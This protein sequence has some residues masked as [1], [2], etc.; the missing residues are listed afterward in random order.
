MQESQDWLAALP[1][2]LWAGASL[3]PCAYLGRLTYHTRE[4]RA[5]RRRFWSADLI[6]DIPT[7]AGMA[8]VGYGVTDYLQLSGPASAA[9][10]GV[11]GYLGPR[12]VEV[13]AG[14]WVRRRQP[15]RAEA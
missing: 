8:L 9:M 2:W 1:A 13:L 4:V 5:G 12:G 14:W 6:L 11:L 7:A 3:V 15:P 10:T